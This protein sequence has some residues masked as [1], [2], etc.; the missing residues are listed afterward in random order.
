VYSGDDSDHGAAFGTNVDSLHILSDRPWGASPQN[1]P[2]ALL[3]QGSDSHEKGTVMLKKD[4]QVFA[5][6]LSGTFGI[7]ARLRYK[8]DE[9]QQ[10]Q[11][12]WCINV[13]ANEED[14]END[15]EPTGIIYQAFVN[16]NYTGVA[17]VT[18]ARS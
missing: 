1:V 2:F 4:A 14:A 8:G 5:D 11:A 17:E 18:A 15:A 16:P 3:V 12:K 10:T 13:Y 7:I 9:E 6:Y